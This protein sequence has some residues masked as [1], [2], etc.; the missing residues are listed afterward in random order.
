MLKES[1]IQ[2]L[3]KNELMPSDEEL[4]HQEVDELQHHGIK[5]MKWGV[6]RTPE[7]LGHKPSKISSMISS[8][9]KKRAKAKKQK[10]AAKKKKEAAKKEKEEE[11]EDKIREKALASTDP[12]YIYKHRNLLTTKELQDRLTRI[13]TEAKVK[14]LTEDDK[15]KKAMKKGEDTLKSLGSMAESIGKIADA[16]TK[17]GEAYSKAEKRVAERD[18]RAQKKLSATVKEAKNE[19]K[20]SEKKEEKSSNESSENNERISIW[21]AMASANAADISFNPKTGALNIK[22]KK[23]R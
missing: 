15:T 11:S 23:K 7:E 6:R 9:K 20:K 21:D 17:V 3:L 8:V 19:Q 14:K 2:E 1:E 10:A 5:G 18:E 12:K 4:E 13:D 16:Y 22:R